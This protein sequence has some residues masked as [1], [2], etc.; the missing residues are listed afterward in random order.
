MGMFAG[1]VD[2]MLEEMWRS[3][4]ARTIAPGDVALRRRIEA[5]RTI[6]DHTAKQ[7]AA[8][9]LI[10]ELG[11]R[12]QSVSALKTDNIPAN[13]GEVHGQNLELSTEIEQVVRMASNDRVQ[14]N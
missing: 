4:R 12:I 9:L 2:Q 6:N 8:I 1:S 3:L 14:I 13:F 11:L 10:H 5:L 7:Q